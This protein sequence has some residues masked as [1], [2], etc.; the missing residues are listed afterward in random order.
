M[1]GHGLVNGAAA[2]AALSLVDVGI[3]IWAMLVVRGA[4]MGARLSFE[5]LHY[6]KE[7]GGGRL[8]DVVVASGIGRRSGAL[9]GGLV[10]WCWMFRWSPDWGSE[11]LRGGII[12]V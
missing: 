10:Q 2:A 7:V 4:E 8:W 5:I 12:T 6:S 9:I 1:L 3:R 11:R